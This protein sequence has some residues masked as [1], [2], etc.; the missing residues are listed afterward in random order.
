MHS[1][2]ERRSA[3]TVHRRQRGITLLENLIALVVLSIGLLGHANLQNLGLRTNT[4][5]YWRTQ[6]SILAIDIADRMRANPAGIATGG[7]NDISTLPEDA[8]CI[9]TFCTPLAMAQTDA[10]SWQQTLA[11]ELP[12]GSGSVVGTGTGSLFTIKIRWQEIEAD[13]A[14]T[15]EFT[16]AVIP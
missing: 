9:D 10:R 14:V 7:Y 13:G 1:V 2:S 6:A 5:S 16:M 4:H 12:Q 3:L 15:K 11:R 8:N